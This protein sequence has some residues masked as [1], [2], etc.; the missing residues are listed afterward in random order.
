M[1]ARALQTPSPYRLTLLQRS[2]NH[3]EVASDLIKRAEDSVATPLGSL[4]SGQSPS[5][6]LHSP[7]SSV[8]S[9]ACT[10]DTASTSPTTSISSLEDLVAKVESQ[11]PRKRM[12]KKVSFSLPAERTIMEEEPMIRP[13]SPTLG[14]DEDY[15]TLSGRVSPISDNV[16]PQVISMPCPVRAPPPVP[17]RFSRPVSILKSIEAGDFMRNRSISRYR[18]HLS[19]LQSQVNT[20]ASSVQELLSPINHVPVKET[21]GSA[22]ATEG[23][24]YVETTPLE[25]R[26]ARIERLRKSGWQRKRFDAKRYEDLRHSVMAELA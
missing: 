3:Y 15:Y 2:R 13:D 9:F 5:S 14:F 4:L 25:D 19:A 7:T 17:Q 26:K 18:G 11:P 16:A 24:G 23:D 20:H 22:L 12:K 8:S 21:H 1:C 6:S 10:A